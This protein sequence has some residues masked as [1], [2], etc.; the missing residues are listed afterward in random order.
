MQTKEIS[1][2][3][4]ETGAAGRY[5]AA[6]FRTEL[7]D[8]CWFAVYTRSR[9]E[10]RV[11]ARLAD[12]GVVYF[13][14]LFSTIRRWKDR[15]KCV[16][17]PLF[18]GYLFVRIA[19]HERLRVLQV[20]GV[21]RLVGF[22]GQPVPL[23]ESEIESLRT[24]LASHLRA[25]PHPYLT[26]GRRIRVKNGPLKGVE[27]ILIRKKNRYRVVISVDLIMRSAVVEIDLPDIERIA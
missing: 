13:L 9:H 11:A 15:K 20:P 21:V 25:E 24:G 1:K 12:N 4:N 14:P 7:V 26:V 27:G 18:P 16:E 17:L 22:N 10:R 23:P 5:L 6:R 19:L 8:P 2:R 3:A